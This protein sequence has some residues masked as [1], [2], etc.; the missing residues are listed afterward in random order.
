MFH[1]GTSG[2]QYRDW[3]GRFYPERLP[4]RGWLAHYARRFETVE[5][6]NSFYRLPEAATFA[7]WR[8]QTPDGFL[9][10]VKASRYLT[11]ILRLR[12]PRE[13]VDL[14]LER[15][16][17]AEEA[18]GPVLFQ[19]PP[20]LRAEPARLR[21]TLDAIGGRVMAAFEFRH[22]S[23]LTDEVFSVL[24]DAGAALV[25][26]D[27][28]GERSEPRVTGGWSY[29]RFHQ[30]TAKRSG[31]RRDALR[32]WA[33]RLVALPADDTF[34]YFNNDPGAAAPR[35]AARL[36]ELLRERGVQVRSPTAAL[37]SPPGR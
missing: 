26:A 32:W 24:E 21:E 16:R 22:P 14:L 37:R 20:N 31:Y 17:A 15:A 9:I 34:V 8:E 2:W 25:L 10:A 3:R 23:W 1:V 33:D 5:V 13:A 29:V 12:E 35:D 19:L 28:A 7:R 6:N 36:A 27:R 4:Q 18:L 11:H 30:G